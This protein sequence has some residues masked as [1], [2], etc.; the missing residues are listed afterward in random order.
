MPT[1]C[2]EC[3]AERTAKR[4]CPHGARAYALGQGQ[5]RRGYHQAKSKPAVPTPK[6]QDA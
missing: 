1:V 5:W 4:A 6:S 2:A 3:A